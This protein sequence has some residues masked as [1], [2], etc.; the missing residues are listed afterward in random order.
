MHCP[1]AELNIFVDLFFNRQASEQTTAAAA[2]LPL[3]K[4][5][6]KTEFFPKLAPMLGRG[7]AY[8]YRS[9]MKPER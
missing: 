6:T 1:G 5:Q 3:A 8:I 2:S 4:N 7:L 9:F